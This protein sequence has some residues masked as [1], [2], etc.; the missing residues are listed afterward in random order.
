MRDSNGSMNRHKIPNPQLFSHQGP[1]GRHRQ[2]LGQSD[3]SLYGKP[4]MPKGMSYDGSIP[5]L[6]TDTNVEDEVN[7]G[8]RS[9]LHVPENLSDLPQINK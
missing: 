1:V 3:A 6:A 5:N 9:A 8:S 2:P 7:H 4:P